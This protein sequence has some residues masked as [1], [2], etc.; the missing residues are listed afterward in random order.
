MR[1]YVTIARRHGQKNWN[2]MVTPDQP[3]KAHRKLI[4]AIRGKPKHP[5]FAEVQFAPVS[6][7]FNLSPEYA[8]PVQAAQKV[9]PLQEAKPVTTLPAK[10][11]K[12]LFGS[13]IARKPSSTAA[14]A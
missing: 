12:S 10:A 9:E 6:R 3:Y 4:K 11:A 14:R 1:Q 7:K 5:D 2:V 8:K 13:R